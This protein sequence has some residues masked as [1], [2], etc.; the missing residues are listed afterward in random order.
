MEIQEGSLFLEKCE[1]CEKWFNA[2]LLCG[3]EQ[4]HRLECAECY[5]L[6]RDGVPVKR[7]NSNEK[8]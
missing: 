1:G 7:K 8:R 4:T 5:K 2:K 3:N 6:W